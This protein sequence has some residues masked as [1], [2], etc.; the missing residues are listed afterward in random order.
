MKTNLI[1]QGGNIMNEKT[2]RMLMPQWQGGNNEAYTLGAELLAWLA[3]E[4]DDPFVEVPIE[5]NPEKIEKKEGIVAREALLKQVDA[6]QNLISAHEPDRIVMFGGDCLVGQAPYAYLNERYEGEL[7]VL[8]IDSHGDI[9]TP[10]EMTNAN[11]MV[12]ANLLGEGDEEFTSKVDVPLNPENVMFAGVKPKDFETERIEKLGLHIAGPEKLKENSDL[13]LQW[14]SDQNIKHLAIH[15]DVDVL[16]PKL[17]RSQ[18]FAKP[19]PVTVDWAEGEMTLSQIARLINDV[20]NKTDVAGLGI[21]EHMPWYAINLK[22]FLEE[23]PI[24]NQK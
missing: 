5:N 11:T 15:F 20:S 22:K 7:G 17:F 8:W 6:A 4:N 16:D 2:L 10:N 19:E 23:L 13:I 3:P 9:S 1:I 24:L 21:T 12:L 14:I 18:I